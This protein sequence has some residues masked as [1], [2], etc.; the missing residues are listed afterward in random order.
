MEWPNKA[1]AWEDVPGMV[2]KQVA[3]SILI[4]FISLFITAC[5][6]EQHGLYISPNSQFIGKD[7][8]KG[9]ETS[10]SA[11]YKESQ[12]N[13]RVRADNVVTSAEVMTFFE[14]QLESELGRVYT[15]PKIC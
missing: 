2:R 3:R 4:V 7:A 11:M 15:N 14:S 1:A 5:S 8:S 6:D 10:E 12:D 13:E 9:Y